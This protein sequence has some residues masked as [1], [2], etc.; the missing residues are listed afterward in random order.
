M[1]WLTRALRN[2][3]GIGQR[4]AVPSGSANGASSF[5][6]AW[7]MP[8]ATEPAPRLVEVSAVLEVQVPPSVEALYFWALQV[9]LADAQGV[10]GGAHTG[11]QWNP[12]FPDGTAVNWGGYVSGA[13]GGAVLPGTTSSLPS[14]AGDPNTVAYPWVPGRAYRLRVYASP[15]PASGW[16]SEVTD[17]ASGDASVIRDLLPPS[18]RSASGGYLAR[19]IVWAEVFA[20]CDAPSVTVRWSDLRAVDAAGSVVRPDAVRVN[21]QAAQAGGCPNTTVASDRVGGLFQVTSVPRL[22]EQGTILPLTGGAP[23][24]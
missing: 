13:G 22:V 12:R 20:S 23:R 1:S 24:V 6:L 4:Q 19:P 16:R 8:A 18:G 10:W 21:Y 11:L 7:E 5:H 14:F 15:E 3:V 17:L 2:L 9:D